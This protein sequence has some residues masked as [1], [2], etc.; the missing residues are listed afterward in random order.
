MNPRSQALIEQFGLQPHPEGGFYRETFRSTTRVRSDK[1]EGERAALTSIYFLLDGS[2]YSAWHKVASDESW[3]F[4]VGA[5][6]DIWML[7]PNPA[8]DA[9]AVRIATIGPS[10]G[11]F[12]MTVPAGTWFA[13]Q[14]TARDGFSLVSC[15]VSPGFEFS[16]FVLATRDHLSEEGYGAH[17]DWPRIESFLSNS[18]L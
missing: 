9:S 17:P 11:T 7:K 3:L 12:E 4:H 15:V 2:Q 14:P 8:P 13:A 10:C 16:D 5:D 1:H 18:A 6:L